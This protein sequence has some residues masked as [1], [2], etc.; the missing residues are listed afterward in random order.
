MLRPV[1]ELPQPAVTGPELARSEKKSSGLCQTVL[2]YW[3]ASC[4]TF[5]SVY[6]FLGPLNSPAP[7]AVWPALQLCRETPGPPRMSSSSP[8]QICTKTV[9]C[10]SSIFLTPWA[11]P[12]GKVGRHP[13]TQHSQPAVSPTPT[14]WA[15]L[16]T[17]RGCSMST[18]K[19]LMLKERIKQHWERMW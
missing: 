13:L 10:T 6:M 7:A 9:L 17:W 16:L 2:L 12:L 19:T 5:D 15:T 8:P 11:A 14:L 3:T 4:M 18:G 1:P